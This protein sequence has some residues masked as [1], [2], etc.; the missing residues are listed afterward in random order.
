MTS[1]TKRTRTSRKKDRAGNARAVTT[2][3]WRARYRDASGKQH[4]R[5]FARKTDAQQWL[6]EVTASQVAGTYVHPRTAKTTVGEWCDTWLAGYATRRPSTVRQARVHLA[7]IRAE[8][9]TMALAT[10]RPSHVRSWTARLRA[11]GLSASYVYALHSRLAQLFADAVH[12]GIVPR[13]P[14]SRRTSPGAG[15]Q[16]PYVAT[17]EQVW[18]LYDAMPERFS[19]AVLLAA[20]AG[21]RLAESCGLRAADLDFIR[22]VVHPQVQYPA[23]ELKTDVSRTP[24]PVARSLTLVLSA[25]VARWPG[26]TVLTDDAGGQVGPWKLERAIRSARARVC[27]CARCSIVQA[28]D[29]RRFR[30]ASCGC[31]DSEAGLPAGFRY[32]DLRHYFASLL[33]AS[34]ADVKTVQARLRHASAKTTLDTY[35]HL[36]P[37]R[38][39]STRAATEAV[40]AARLGIPSGQASAGD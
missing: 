1:I 23:E 14:C 35:G 18:A 9:G 16:R 20:F 2:E 24:V 38:D 36:W 4:E 10:V 11:G 12:D 29:A 21:L 39:E 13:S 34:G 6:N 37:D 5:H 27:R 22:A 3:F 32:H 40:I 31:G 19:A 26:E 17:T 15:T 33:I 25:H 28:A 8:F 7:Q 30:C